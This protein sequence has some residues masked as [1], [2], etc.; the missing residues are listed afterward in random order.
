[1]AFLTRV[2][3]FHNL[4]RINTRLISRSILA[5]TT[6]EPP[7]FY[8][9]SPSNDSFSKPQEDNLNHDEP[10]ETRIL[11]NALKYVPQYGFSNEALAQGSVDSGYSNATISIF[12]NGP[13]DL[14]NFFYKDSN[15]Q[16]EHYLEELKKDGIKYKTTELIKMA[17]IYR[18]KLTQPYIKHWP[19]AMA[20]MTFNPK[21][22][23]EAID[24]LLKLVDE[25]WHQAGDNST[26]VGL[27]NSNS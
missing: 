7:K 19:Q 6:E 22:A 18:L 2:I 13:F 4:T 12:K 5:Q 26:D 20:I 1:M 3:K 9:N 15:R 24:N 23:L 10:I 8:E 25:I 21:Y 17:V 11:R 16:L 14:I 27:K